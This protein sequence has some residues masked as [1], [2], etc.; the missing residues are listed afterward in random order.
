MSDSLQPITASSAATTAPAPAS[1]KR[2]RWT[3]LAPIALCVIIAVLPAPAG[4]TPEAWRYFA[5]FVGVILGLI[6]EPIPTPII[7]V[8]GVVVAAALNLVAKTPADS[9][10]W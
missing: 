6:L 10:K 2:N 9:V 3:A 5:V 8:I 1:P 4:L 7:A